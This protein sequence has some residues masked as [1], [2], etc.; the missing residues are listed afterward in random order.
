V[1]LILPNSAWT[2]EVIVSLIRLW[3]IGSGFGWE[4]G[5]IKAAW[6]L[7]PPNSTG[8]G[9]GYLRVKVEGRR[10]VIRRKSSIVVLP[11]SKLFILAHS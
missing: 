3:R 5:Y 8:R 2:A 1:E 6:E 10:V 9:F 4:V 7:R 11:N